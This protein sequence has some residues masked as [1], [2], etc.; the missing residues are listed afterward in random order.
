MGSLLHYT[1][2]YDHVGW[3]PE[4]P[5]NFNYVS[6]PALPR[7]QTIEYIFRAAIDQCPQKDVR[8]VLN[9]LYRFLVFSNY[10]KFDDN[11]R[12]PPE[13]LRELDEKYPY[14]HCLYE[15]EQFSSAYHQPGEANTTGAVLYLLMH[16][17]NSNYVNHLLG[18]SSSQ[19]F[20]T[21][22]FPK[23]DRTWQRR[24]K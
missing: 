8:G 23:N 5:F 13:S 16:S 19:C 2:Q 21:S 4:P 22:T 10:A 20:R 24:N 7:G 14:A 6:V 9:D 18:V 12:E 3:P 17:R 11:I 1:I 15:A